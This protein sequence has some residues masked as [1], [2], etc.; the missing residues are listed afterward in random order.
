M[1]ALVARALAALVDHGRR[2]Q[3]LAGVVHPVH[4]ALDHAFQTKG[5]FMGTLSMEAAIG[6]ALTDRPKGGDLLVGHKDRVMDH[7]DRCTWACTVCQMDQAGH[8]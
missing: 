1:K 7:L 4:P 6:H 2:G 8:L 5:R 3:T